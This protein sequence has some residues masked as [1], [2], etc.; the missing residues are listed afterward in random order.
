MKTSPPHYDPPKKHQPAFVPPKGKRK[1]KRKIPEKGKIES[2]KKPNITTNPQKEKKNKN[3][4]KRKKTHREKNQIEKKK[5]QTKTIKQ[6][7]NLK[8]IKK[9]TDKKIKNQKRKNSKSESSKKGEKKI[10]L[11]YFFLFILIGETQTDQFKKF[12]GI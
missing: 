11:I 6:Q 1:R 5:L 4:A 9:I 12:V 8:K 3:K 10:L 2:I 7:K